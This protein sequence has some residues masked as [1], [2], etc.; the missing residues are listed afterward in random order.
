MTRPFVDRP[1]P[2]EP[3]R[4]RCPGCA[5]TQLQRSDAIAE[6]YRCGRCHWYGPRDDLTDAKTTD[7]INP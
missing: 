3:W 2:E 6:K 4:W 5:S 1:D 7:T